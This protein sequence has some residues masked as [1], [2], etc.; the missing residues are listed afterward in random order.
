MNPVTQSLRHRRSAPA[1]INRRSAWISLI[2]RGTS[3][4]SFVATTE[5]ELSPASIEDALGEIGSD[6]ATDIQFFGGDEI[7]IS[8]KF[9]AQLV[10]E[11]ITAIGYLGVDAFNAEQCAAA[12]LALQ[13]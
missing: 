7:K 1:A 6:H 12:P 9:L 11:V 13:A 4:F 8:Y 2:E 5:K 10:R 3:V